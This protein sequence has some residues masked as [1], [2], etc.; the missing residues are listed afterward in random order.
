MTLSDTQDRAAPLTALRAFDAA[1][2][3][4]SFAKAAAEL[5]VTPA[6]LSYQIKRLED[7]L[8]TPLFRR[9]N[10][11]VELTEAGRALQ[12]G[13][14]E[15]FAAFA[16]AQRAVRRLSDT[17]TLTITAGPAFTAKWLA[18]RLFRFAALHPEVEL[19][20]V[21]SFRILD[22]ER[23]EVDA[24]I[25]FGPTT[26]DS[27]FCWD[28]SGEWMA[29]MCTPE[30]AATLRSPADLAG[31]TLLHDDHLA[32]GGVT[33]VGWPDWLAK[34]GAYPGLGR[35][36]PRFS[37]A[38]H[39]IDAAASGGGV[40]LGRLLLAERELA[41]GRLVL[42]FRAALPTAGRYR[43][44]CPAG[45]QVRPAVA[46]FLRWLQGETAATAKGIARYH[47]DPL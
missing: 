33:A 18:P 24:A 31:V 43:F 1:A 46:A 40:V 27:L 23:D 10:R 13:L 20:F 15:G 7:H 5:S 8:G 37:N 2:R 29:P 47:D 21:A 16:S 38:D 19:R 6:A 11:A 34:A 22:F 44:F 45:A 39:A 4:M 26:D 30:I 14:A 42:P 3:H 32:G 41:D 35:R 25:R 12:P 36:G 9:L 17:G 28:M